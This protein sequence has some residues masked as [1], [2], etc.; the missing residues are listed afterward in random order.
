[1]T[2][3]I[4]DHLTKDSVVFGCGNPLFGDDGFGSAVIEHLCEHYSIPTN[5][6]CLDAG[7]AVRDFLFDILLSPQKPR[8]IIIVDA[9][10]IPD[11]VPG[12]IREIPI[13]AIQSN[14]TCDFSLHQFPTTNMLIEIQEHTNISVRVLVVKTAELP[15]EVCPGL[16]NPV[17]QAI[18]PMC[19][20]IMHVL[21]QFIP[22]NG[23]E[24]S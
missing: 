13:D 18:A 21:K 6:A 24:N 11:A 20:H 12:D 2:F 17:K 7:T 4:G 22:A 3:Q 23:G 16:S 14:K 1:M 19:R 10:D 9:M 8:Q 5:V 15:D